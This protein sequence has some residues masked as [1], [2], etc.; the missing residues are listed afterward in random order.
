MN[1]KNKK[2]SFGILYVGLIVILCM[3]GLF[4]DFSSLFKISNYQTLNIIF[5]V[6]FLNVIFLP[7]DFLSDK[8]L[9]SIKKITF[10]KI[11]LGKFLILI[12]NFRTWQIHYSSCHRW[13]Y[14][15]ICLIYI[16]ICLNRWYNY[17]WLKLI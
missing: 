5:F 15:Y 8:A 11:L 13:K 12:R 1:F 6:F 7:F 2:L 17:I 9:N 3:A 10:K 4:Y 16:I 14:S